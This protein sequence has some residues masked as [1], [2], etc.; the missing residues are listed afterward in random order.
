VRAFFIAKQQALLMNMLPTLISLIITAASST[1][2]LSEAN[3]PKNVTLASH[4]MPM[5][6]RY[7]NTFVN[8]VFKDNILLNIAYMDGLVKSKADIDWTKIESDFHYEFT[9]QPR[10]EFA[11]H[12]KVADQYKGKIVK[13]TNA[14][15]NYDDGF[16]SDGYLTG[17]G[18]CHLA[19]IIYWTAK[20]AGLTA[21][22]PTNHNFAVIPD[23]PKEYGVAI[24]EGPEGGQ[25]SNLYI[26]NN[27]EKPVTFVFDYKNGNLTVSTSTNI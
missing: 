4:V 9:L 13:T 26:T 23:V 20:D 24:Y 14:H 21:I 27:K 15:F 1:N 10:E 17:D 16:K 19:S 6:D 25:M 7:G 2:G 11:F 18:V 3:M 8:D 12:D 22:A 5:N